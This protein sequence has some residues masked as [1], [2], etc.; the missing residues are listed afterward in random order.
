MAS[1]FGPGLASGVGAEARPRW[2]LPLGRGRPW[3]SWALDCMDAVGGSGWRMP[4][5]PLHLAHLILAAEA[6]QG[7]G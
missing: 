1:S 6:D 5:F 3:S 2:A 7:T 4:P